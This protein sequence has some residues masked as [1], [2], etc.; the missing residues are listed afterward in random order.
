VK[1]R[2]GYCQYIRNLVLGIARYIPVI[3]PQL[4]KITSLSYLV[5]VLRVD[6]LHG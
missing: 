4:P 3:L 1:Y 5:T 6:M 2:I